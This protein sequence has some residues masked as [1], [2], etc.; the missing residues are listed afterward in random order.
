MTLSVLVVDDSPIARKMLLRALPRNFDI[1]IFQVGS[2]QDALEFCR[3]V[4][5]DLM[6]LD[7]NM[8]EMT[9][10]EVLDAIRQ[11]RLNCQVIVVSA[12]IQ[13]LAQERVKASGA[14]AFLKKPV[15]ASEVQG[16]L[17]TIGL[18]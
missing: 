3:A 6:F 8:P 4:E 14:I 13:T 16:F 5:V 15:K 17:E 10:Y 12:D 11:E 7:L 18:N 2:G 9:G 1:E